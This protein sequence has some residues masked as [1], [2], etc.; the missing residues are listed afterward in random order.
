M[1]PKFFLTALLA[2]PYVTALAVPPQA[3]AADIVVR[4][5][6]EL[7]AEP[8]WARAETEAIEVSDG[9]DV[10]KKGKKGK[11]GKGAK[12]KG[13]KKGKGSKGKG[14]K[15]KG[16]GKGGKGKGGKGKGKAGKGKGKKGK[17]GRKGKKDSEEE[18][19]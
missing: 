6:G 3:D 16:K 1:L 14:K 11:K 13:G 4:D 18:A 5:E 19:S 12:G 9:I 2:V 15:G 10:D 8:I 7:A 17:G